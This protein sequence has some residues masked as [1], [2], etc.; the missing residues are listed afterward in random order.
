[1]HQQTQRTYAIV[2]DDDKGCTALVLLDANLQFVA[3]VEATN[4]APDDFD[5]DNEPIRDLAVHGD[6]VIIL[7]GNNHPKGSGLRLLDLDGRFLRTI[8]AAQFR[9]PQAVAASHGRAFVVDEGDDDGGAYI[10]KVLYVIDIQSGNTLQKVHV[11]TVGETSAILVDSDEVYIA[12]F[13]HSKVEMYRF[14]GSEA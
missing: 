2:S 6:Q 4:A 5:E 8:A 11:G 3:T 12:D 10:D 7:T 13:G 9:R 1:M 14:A